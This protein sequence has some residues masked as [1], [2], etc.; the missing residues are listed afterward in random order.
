[1]AN[2]YTDT[3]QKARL[4]WKG[5]APCGVKFHQALCQARSE[6]APLLVQGIVGVVGKGLNVVLEDA[7][8]VTKLVQ[9]QSRTTPSVTPYAAIQVQNFHTPAYSETDLVT[10][11]FGLT[12]AAMNGTNT[13][14]E[15]GARFDDHRAQRHAAHPACQSSVGARL[16]E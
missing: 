11:G 13:R 15:L 8:G 16:G 3:I 10:G 12:Y 2:F 7:E 6:V 9:R 1:M 4:A 5:S 14:G